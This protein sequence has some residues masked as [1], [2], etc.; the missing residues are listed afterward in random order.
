MLS[1]TYAPA[2]NFDEATG[3]MAPDRVDIIL[4]VSEPLQ[5]TPFLT[6]T[7]DGG[8][9]MSVELSKDNDL[10][11]TGHFT[12]SDG[13][14]EG[15]AYAVFSAR[16]KAGNRGT[17]IDAGAVIRVDGRGPE[18]RNLAVTPM[19]PI[20]NSETEPVSLTVT[21][22]LNDNINPG[23]SPQLSYLLSAPGRTAG[24]IPDITKIPTAPG[25]AETWQAIFTLPADAGQSAPETLAFIHQGADDLG[26]TSS[27]ILAANA[28]QV[29]QGDLPPLPAPDGLKAEKLS[30]GAIKLTW[31]E[32]AEA[33]GYQLYRQAPGES[34]LAPYQRLPAAPEYTDAPNQDGIYKYTVASIRQENGQETISGMSPPVEA[35]SDSLAPEAPA[36][37]S[38][39]LAA[40]GIKVEWS[41]PAYN[42]PV[43][44]NLYRADLPEITSVDGMTPLIH[45]IPQTLVVDPNPSTTQHCY[46]ATAV[47]AAGNESEPSNSVYQNFGLL[48]VS[49]LIVRQTDYD[50]PVITWIHPGGDIAGYDI[51]LGLRSGSV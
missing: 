11:Y 42:E 50:P 41:A 1:I 30:E 8:S 46:V 51:Y 43:T 37:L 5:S 40:N 47:D 49:S 39:E 12:I 18:V 4:D 44:F 7:P 10:T 26:N 45:S 22:G 17:L 13:I 14:S 6:I 2:G 29:Y 33:V 31:N 28:F 3:R 19:E 34:D 23:D 20:K 15:S 9:P 24:D 36:N 21:L 25:D 35:W 32:V 27:R 38:L 16:D 48:P